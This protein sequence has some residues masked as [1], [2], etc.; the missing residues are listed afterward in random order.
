MARTLKQ[1]IDEVDAVKPN[2]FDY[3]TK[4]RWLNEI[5][6]K[7]QTEVMLIASEDVLQYSYPE[8]QDWELLVD[9]P[10]DMIYPAYLTARIDFANGE[11]ERYQNTMQMFNDMYNDFVRWYVAIYAPADAHREGLI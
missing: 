2:A 11:Y 8:N 7:V 1:C 10:Y 4:T 5:E 9:P 6:G 3:A